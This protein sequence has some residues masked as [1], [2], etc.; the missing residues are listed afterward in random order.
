M[1]FKYDIV[2]RLR[3]DMNYS[4]LKPEIFDFK[5]VYVQYHRDGQ[6]YDQFAIGGSESMDVYSNCFA[7]IAQIY[8]QTYDFGGERT[9][10]RYI[11][12]GGVSIG[13]IPE[14]TCWK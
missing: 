7:R 2:V 6:T 11:E 8:Q 10:W 12:F 1:G 14:F 4:L 13:E 9:L 5:N 3:P